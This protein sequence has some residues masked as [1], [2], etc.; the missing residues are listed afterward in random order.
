MLIRN[1]LQSPICSFSPALVKVAGLLLPDPSWYNSATMNVKT[2]EETSAPKGVIGC[3]AAGFEILGR[4]LGLVA[5]PALLDLFLWLG[6]RLSIAPLLQQFIAVLKAQ[7]PPDPE[8]ARQVT[9]AIQLLEQFGEQFNLL[10]LLSWLPL[11]H[12]PSLLARRTWGK[13]SPLGDA[14][15]FSVASL[16]ALIPWWGMLVLAGL[17]LGFLYL[18]HLAHRVRA[19]RDL[20]EPE[21]TPSESAQ[22]EQLA[23]M[24]ESVARPIRVFLFEAGLLAVGVVFILVW[25]LMVGATTAISQPLGLLVWMLGVGLISYVA[26]H[27]VFVIPGVLLGGRGLLQAIWESVVLSHRQFPAM[28]GLV[29]LTMVIY[30]GLG[31]VWS[32]PSGDSWSLLVGILGNAVVATGLTAATFVFYQERLVG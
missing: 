8:M 6:P 1:K 24:S 25:I 9:Q 2:K 20:D 11:L 13:V 19:E 30:E 5:I 10:S 4:N 14:S 18:N 21:S 17:V 32:L 12:P 28:M 16:L 29:L 22:E 15:I 31:Y 26:L 27:L 23:L 7:P 3:L